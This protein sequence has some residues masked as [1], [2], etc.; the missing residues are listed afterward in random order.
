MRSILIGIILSCLVV[1]GDNFTVLIGCDKLPQYIQVCDGNTTPTD[2]VTP[3]P[4]YQLKNQKV[5]WGY[6]DMNG[7]AFVGQIEVRYEDGSVFRTLTGSDGRFTADITPNKS[8]FVYA[9][10]YNM[11]KWSTHSQKFILRISRAGNE[12]W[13]VWKPSTHRWIRLD[14]S[15]KN[16][17]GMGFKE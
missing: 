15:D 13:R 1:A 4:V 16:K 14:L 5:T 12:L 8:F 17:I 11:K 9:Y 7:T 6:G 10:D 2:T 3:A